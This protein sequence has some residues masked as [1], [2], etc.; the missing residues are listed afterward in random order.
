MKVFLSWSGDLS[1]DFATTLQEWLPSVLQTVEP[2]LSAD[3][4]VKGARWSHEL[5][6]ALESST[7]GIICLTRENMNSPWVTFE[8]GALSKSLSSGRV[9]PL[10]IDVSREDM[11][12]PL[13][14]FQNTTLT[15]DDMLKLISSV[16][17]ASGPQAVEQSR[18]NKAYEIWW[19]ELEARL[20]SILAQH[21][22]RQQQR[23]KEQPTSRTFRLLTSRGTLINP[24]DQSRNISFKVETINLIL[25]SLGASLQNSTSLEKARDAFLIAGYAAGKMFGDR[26]LEKW[27]LEFPADN[28]V[29]RLNRWC[30]FD[31]DVGW[32][33]LTNNLCIDE[34]KG[35]IS[36][37]IRLVDNFQT[38]KRS[39]AKH[40]DCSLMFGYIKGVLESFCSG[41]PL[42]VEC[43]QAQ[44]PLSNPF[45]RDCTFEVKIDGGQA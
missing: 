44:C 14:Q 28:I 2:F 31:S 43:N 18:L 11:L 25:S 27:D 22:E 42:S 9:C 10:L 45:K 5:G 3:A 41:V 34:Q 26:I 6:T 33:R 7:F 29:D 36:G 30:D 39:D 24:A 16:N 12:G 32:G 4:I 1:R 17:D 35:Q 20:N 21:N 19:P 13:S 8:A 38:Y 23:V 40:P 37:V 15:K